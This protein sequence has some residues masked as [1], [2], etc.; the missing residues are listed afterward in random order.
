MKRELKQTKDGSY[1]W[2]LPELKEHY[3][4]VHGALQES[5]H[6]FLEAGLRHWWNLH[7]NRV[8][9]ILEVGLGSGLNLGLSLQEAHARQQSICYTALEPFPPEASELALIQKD[10]D[11]AQSLPQP[12]YLK[13]GEWRKAPLLEF[14]WLQK[15]LTKLDREG[16]FDLIYFDAFAPEKQAELWTEEVFRTLYE[17]ANP[18]AVWVSYCAK[19]AVKR[20]L[21]AAAWHVEALPGPPGKREMTRAIKPA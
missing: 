8:P 2:Y 20:A 15:S 9:H 17:R 5:N 16:P 4:S 21:K 19:G 18:G 6:V 13:S 11:W 3:H 7:G 14:C 1:T 12:L 10:Q